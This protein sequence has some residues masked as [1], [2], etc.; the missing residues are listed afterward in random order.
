MLTLNYTPQVMTLVFGKSRLI[1]DYYLISAL[2][3]PKLGN[4]V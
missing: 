1:Q 2:L 4:L 3:A